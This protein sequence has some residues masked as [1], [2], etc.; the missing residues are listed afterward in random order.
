MVAAAHIEGAGIPTDT[1]ALTRLGQHWD[2]VRL[3]LIRQVNTDYGGIFDGLT[4]KVDRWER[5]LE[6]QRIPCPPASCKSSASPAKP[7][8]L[9]WRS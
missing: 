5:W 8:T 6:D 7:P 1:E 2:G 9:R 4:L 3:N